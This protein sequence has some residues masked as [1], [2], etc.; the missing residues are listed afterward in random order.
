MNPCNLPIA[1]ALPKA[2]NSNL[3]T[4]YGVP[5]AFNSSSVTP[6]PDTSGSV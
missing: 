1:F 2:L 5:L 4:W 6:T 3:P